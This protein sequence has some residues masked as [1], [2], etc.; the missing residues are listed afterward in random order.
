LANR[1][2]VI[3]GLTA[4]VSVMFSTQIVNRFSRKALMQF[5][6][7]IDG[8]SYWAM[9][10]YFGKNEG[11]TGFIWMLVFQ[12]AYQLSIGPIIWIYIPE[13]LND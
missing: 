3:I 4:A 9:A 10:Y 8:I 2:T 1:A 5:G 11:K 13:T 6:I 12:V 7:I